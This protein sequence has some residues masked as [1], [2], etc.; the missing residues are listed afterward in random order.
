MKFFKKKK[1]GREREPGCG[2]N[3][4]L[5]YRKVLDGFFKTRA[6]DWY[7]EIGSRDGRSLS[8]CPCNYVAIDIEFKVEHDVFNGARQ[9][10]FFQESSDDFFASEFLRRNRI[11]PDLAFVD[12]LHHFEF[13]LRDFINCERNMGSGG[14]ICL[15]DVSP[16]NTAM[17]TRDTDYTN[18]LK[19]PWTGDV[20]KV[21][22]ALLDFRPDLDINILNAEATGLGCIGNLDPTNMVLT[23]RYDEIIARYM[24]INLAETGPSAYFDRFDLADAA[25]FLASQARDP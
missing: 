17:T 24:D 4:G 21:I 7:V 15:H 13:A 25:A 9:M 5:H 23:E 14:L 19:R 11:R 16:Y 1:P 6:P 20:W 10:L 2:E 3:N 12:G 8:M 18:V 22:A